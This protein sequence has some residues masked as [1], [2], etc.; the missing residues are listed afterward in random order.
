MKFKKRQALAAAALVLVLTGAM[1]ALSGAVKNALLAERMAAAQTVEAG[2]RKGLAETFGNLDEA[3]KLSYTIDLDDSD[4]LEP[5]RK[6]AR[7][8]VEENAHIAYAA[9]FREDTLE[10][11]YP[12]ERFGGL[13]GKDMADFA[14]SVTLAKFAKIPVVEGPASLDGEGEDVFLF[15]QPLYRGADY[16]GE[17]VVAM[18]S[19]YVLSSL[20]L[21]ELEDGGY[22]YELWRLDFLGQTKTVI[23]SSNP[24]ADY[25][26]AVKH[27]FSLPATWNISIL[28]K[29]GWIT[30]GERAAIGLCALALGLVLLLAAA[31]L[32]RTAY[33]QK[34]LQVAKYTDADSGLAT[35]EGFLFFVDKRLA[36]AQDARL[37][38]LQVQLGG[39][40]RFT[41]FMGRE[42]L[43]AFLMRFRQ[44]ILDC[45]PEDTIATRLNDDTFLLAIFTGE[46][47]DPAR[48]AEDFV[49]QLHWK[50]RLEGRKVFITPRYCTVS[51]PED[52]RDALS[53]VQ[54]AGK[55]FEAASGRP[56]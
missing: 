27:A 38:V 12:E 16:I 32:W 24:A 35:M 41:K 55:R 42:E 39:F 36:K 37:C 15:L 6:R 51:Y 44:G 40:R 54:V 31:L 9:Y 34:R 33:L 25:S 30:R 22:D 48:M 23:Q 56:G 10:F 47:Q 45:F 46:G 52:G 7:R 18:D 17:A 3:E 2:F 4:N 1:L 11:I 53:L 26:D 5:F 50:R 13:A 29:G 43:A 21:E 28:P 14:Y 19:G 49:L 8:L 20:G